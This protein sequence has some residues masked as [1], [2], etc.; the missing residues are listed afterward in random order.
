MLNY[1]SKKG[2]N[3]KKFFKLISILLLLTLALPFMI[4]CYIITITSIAEVLIMLEIINFSKAYKQGKKAVDNISLK[5]DIK[6]IIKT[7]L[8]VIKKEGAR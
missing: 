7:V 5:M 8:A 6:I 1:K 4:A 2:A 3:M